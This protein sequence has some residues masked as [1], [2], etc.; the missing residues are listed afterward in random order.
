MQLFCKK[1]SSSLRPLDPPWR[2]AWDSNPRDVLPPTR[3]RVEVDIQI[4]VENKRSS[5]MMQ[6][7]EKPC[8]IKIFRT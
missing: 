2:R 7:F 5:A 4:F 3:F 6:E 1:E 8:K